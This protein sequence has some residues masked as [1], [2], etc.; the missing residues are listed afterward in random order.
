MAALPDSVPAP[1]LRWSYDDGDWMIL[2]LDDVEGT[3]PTEPWNPA[4]FAQVLTALEQLSDALTPATG[5]HRPSG[6]TERTVSATGVIRLL[7]LLLRPRP[8]LG[9]SQQAKQ[10]DP[11]ARSAGKLG[12]DR[13]RDS[14]GAV[15]PHG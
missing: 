14:R 12:S 1:R 15:D 13:W 11:T 8:R 5:T 3:M 2:I 4:Q 6:V 9:E 10:G 7:R